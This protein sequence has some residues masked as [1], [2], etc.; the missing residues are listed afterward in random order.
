MAPVQ[1]DQLIDDALKHHSLKD[2]ERD[3]LRRKMQEFESRS[4]VYYAKPGES[5]YH[6]VSIDSH[7]T[8]SSRYS[9]RQPNRGA[10]SHNQAIELANMRFGKLLAL[11]RSGDRGLT[12]YWVCQCDCGERITLE[13]YSLIDGKR[14]QCRK[15]D[16]KERG[17]LRDKKHAHEYKLE[18]KKF[19]KLTAMSI[20]DEKKGGKRAWVCKCECGRQINVITYRL[21][22]GIVKSCGKCKGASN[23]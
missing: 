18:G 8:D 6:S 16:A 19:N 7:R 22:S 10:G 3:E 9:V 13:K 23:V 15:C 20:A 17:K 1:Q 11:R 4:Q 14:T 12:G 2:T 21:M 5:A